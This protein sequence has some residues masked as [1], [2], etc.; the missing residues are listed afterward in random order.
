MPPFMH[1]TLRQKWGGGVCWNVHFVLCTHTP[2]PVP[3]NVTHKVDN[4]HK[5]S[6]IC[7]PLCTLLWG[8]SGEGVFAG[9]FILY[10]AHAPLPWFFEML[11]IKLITTMNMVKTGS[12]TECVLWKIIPVLVLILS[13]EASKQLAL[14]VVTGD[15]G[16]LP[17][18]LILWA[19]KTLAVAS[20]RGYSDSFV[21]FYK[22]NKANPQQC[23]HVDC[24]FLL[25]F[26]VFSSIQ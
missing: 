21:C 16:R 22:H 26:F 17:S 5:L 20:E 3:C 8:K 2:S 25:L 23:T 12:F 14:L 15:N 19:A 6:K 1:T 18:K 4:H 13:R 11:H 9:M 10:Y 24:F 7:P